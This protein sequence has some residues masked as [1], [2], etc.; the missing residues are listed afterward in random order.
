MT[1]W[2]QAL[3]VFTSAFLLDGAWIK[4]MA[5]ARLK[6]AGIAS[7]WAAVLI[8]LSGVNVV[9]YVQNHWL[10]VVASLGAA[11]GTYTFLKIPHA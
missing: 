11:C 8:L 4:Y 7:A 5:A 10:L 3:I 9:G 2:L 6:K 1:L